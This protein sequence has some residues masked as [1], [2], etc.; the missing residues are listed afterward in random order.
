MTTWGMARRVPGRWP[1]FIAV[2]TVPD[3]GHVAEGGGQQ[4]QQQSRFGRK[5][6]T[7]LVGNEEGCAD[8]PATSICNGPLKVDE[9]NYEF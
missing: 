5:V 6:I 4:K 8:R 7:Q 2:E 3:D 9:K 1:P